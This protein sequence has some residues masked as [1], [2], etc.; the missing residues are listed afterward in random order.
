[1]AREHVRHET[2]YPREH[3]GHEAR[4]ARENLSLEGTWDTK[5]H[6]GRGI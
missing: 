1:M 3:V 5:E 2:N 6:K 4:E